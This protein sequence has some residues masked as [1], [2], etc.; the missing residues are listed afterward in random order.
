MASFFP[1]PYPDELLYSLIARF[2]VRS[3]NL[4]P[5]ATIEEL[6]SSR[7]ASSIADMPCNIDALIKAA[8]AFIKLNAEQLIQDNTLYPYYMVFQTNAKCNEIMQAMRSSYGG[9]IHTKVG[10]MASTIK[11]F[12]NLRFCHKCIETDLKVYG[13]YYWHRIHQAPGVMVCPEHGV[14]IQDS[15]VNLLKTNKHE[16]IAADNANCINRLAAN[17][18]SIDIAKFYEL[19][20][21]TQWLFNNYKKVRYSSTFTNGLRDSYLLS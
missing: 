12:E 16:F 19:A 1:T 14:I 6:F 7:T 11:S 18:S 4:S 2:H 17:Y 3:G 10:I 21:D 9:D 20:K 15:T 5:K 8:P 13:E